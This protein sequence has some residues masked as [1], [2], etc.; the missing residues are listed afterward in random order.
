[1]TSAVFA[2]LLVSGVAQAGPIF[3]TGHDPDFHAQDNAGARNLLRAGVNFVRHG[4]PLPVLFVES[5]LNAIAGHRVGRLGMIA[6]GYVQG[7]D[8][9]HK[10]A[11]ALAA[12]TSTQWANLGSTYS[13][14]VVASD[15]G[16]ML[17]QAELNQLNAHQADIAAFVNAGGGVCALA[18]SGAAGNLTTHDRFAFLPISIVSSS[19]ASP[20]Y[21]VTP[22]GTSTFALAFGDVNSPSHSH[23]DATFGLNVV[24]YS[25]PTGQIMTLAGTVG[26]VSCGFLNANAGPDQTVDGGLATPIALDGSGSAVGNSSCGPLTYEWTE[27]GNVLVPVSGDATANVALDP[28]VHV[29]T[30]TVT[31]NRGESASDTVT[32]TVVNTAPPSI[33]CPADVATETDP[34]VCDA[35]VAYEG[36]WATPGGA[37]LTSV[38]CDW[39][40]GS[41]F[42]AGVTTVH[43][44]AF[45]ASGN[46]A[47]CT[48]A[49]TVVDHE[50]PV[51]IAPPGITVSADEDC[52]AAAPD[53]LE[54]A[55]VTDNCTADH[56]LEIEQSP[57]AG[58]AQDLGTTEITI[59][60]MDESGNVGTGT[61]SI[62][63][64][65][66][67]A[68]SIT[69]AGA[70]PAVL[71]PPNH[72]LVPVTVSVTATDQCSAEQC[73]IVGV[74][75]NEPLNDAGD[76]NTSTDWEITS[77]LTLL[78][79]AERAGPLSGRIYTIGVVC[80]DAAGNGT[81]TSVTVTVPHDQRRR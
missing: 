34:G 40:S 56:H 75:S 32:I 6:S 49:I 71:W 12:M 55:V 29:L 28:G 43:C 31:D 74:T 13:A 24:T 26:I 60:A 81:S 70:S 35:Q 45:D 53:V 11:A 10:N 52:S 39:A 57:T 44:A 65:D 47:E 21:Q 16:G 68:P 59:S 33:V 37:N 14:I 17:T 8:F 22:Y 73:S 64:E 1:M 42:V 62:T 58:S 78:L 25:G 4:S 61:T 80:T 48:F 69:A 38:G 50:P 5:S 2:L 18:E 7:T 72:K 20:P 9:V 51:V 30:L 76:G 3:L 15:F 41:A 36:P 19:N 27:G 63:V 77:S 66:T 79:R 46:S 67:T 23:F 54:S